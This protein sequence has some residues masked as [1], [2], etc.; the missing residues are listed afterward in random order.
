MTPT[1]PCLAAV[2]CTVGV[3]VMPAV[4]PVSTIDPPPASTRWGS[5]TLQVLHT[6]GE[7]VL[8]RRRVH[9]DRRHRTAEVHRD[10]VGAL[11]G[12]PE[13]VAAPL[14]GDN[15]ADRPSAGREEEADLPQAI[16]ASGDSSHIFAGI[17]GM[18][19]RVG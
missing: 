3:P 16:P 10:D 5:P 17:D 6:P 8:G 9:P 1:T 18:P 2:W 7:V 13:R 11:L 12:Q 14:R 19:R 15:T 4:E